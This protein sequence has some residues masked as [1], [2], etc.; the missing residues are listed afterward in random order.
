MIY[1]SFTLDNFSKDNANRQPQQH[2]I[3]NRRE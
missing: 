2:I 3:A 1:R